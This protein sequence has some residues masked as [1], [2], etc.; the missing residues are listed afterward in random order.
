LRTFTL[1]VLILLAGSAF[2]ATEAPE[3][4]QLRD[5]LKKAR[6]AEDKSAI[7]E[8]SQRI[9]AFAPNDSKTWETLAQTQLENEELYDLERTL[10]AW[11]KAFK[12]PP[13]GIEDFRAGNPAVSR[14]NISWRADVTSIDD[15]LSP[16]A[17]RPRFSR[18]K[19]ASVSAPKSRLPSRRE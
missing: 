2:A 13:P 4:N 15:K 10:N 17:T 7:I 14:M 19:R 1:A 18:Q 8:L 16:E 6:E 12:K 11:Q 5:Q 3:L 9:V